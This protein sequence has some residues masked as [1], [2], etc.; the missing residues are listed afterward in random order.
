VIARP[1]MRDIGVA[2]QHTLFTRLR[3]AGS[4]PIVLDSGFLLKA[5]VAVLKKLCDRCGIA[6][7]QRMAHWPPGPKAY[8][9]V[10]ARHWYA[11][12]HRTTGFEAPSG[13]DVRPL[14]GH[15]DALYQEAR[16]FYE[17]LLPF[18]LKA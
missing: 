11:N 4:D 7:Q 17:K 18:S 9:G 1:V 13:A 6:F 12:V 8:D 10:W 5:P 3:E 16:Y 15:L 14:P 2:Y